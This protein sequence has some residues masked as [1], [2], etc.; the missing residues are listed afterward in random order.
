MTFNITSINRFL[1]FQLP[2][3]FF[4]GIRLTELTE[5]KS[6]FTVKHRWINQNPFRSM[7]FAVQAMAAEISTGVLVMRSIQNSAQKISM[8]VTHQKADFTK[9]ATG[10]IKF[11]CEDGATI[12]QVIHKA[13]QTGEGQELVLRSVGYDEQ[14][15]VV[16]KFEFHWSIKAKS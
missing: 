8:L 1:L 5:Q 6:V 3:A 15:V 9:K 10:K 14:N 7:Y 11:I 2:A 16:S 13:I 4:T 12:D